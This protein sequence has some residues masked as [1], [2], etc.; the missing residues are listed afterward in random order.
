MALSWLRG[1]GF[2]NG[3]VV[4]AHVLMSLERGI[5]AAWM[6]ESSAAQA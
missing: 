3:K 6:L 4:L 2:G 5:H 1:M